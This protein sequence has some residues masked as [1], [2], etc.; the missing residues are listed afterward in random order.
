MI[1]KGNGGGFVYFGDF[2]FALFLLVWE[3]ENSLVEDVSTFWKFRII[4]SIKSSQ[5]LTYT[6]SSI[7]KKLFSQNTYKL[8]PLK[9]LL[10]YFQKCYA[11]TIPKSRYLLFPFSLHD[12]QVNSHWGMVRAKKITRYTLDEWIQ[13]EWMGENQRK[14]NGWLPL[15]VFFYIKGFVYSNYIYYF[16]CEICFPP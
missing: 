8:S 1:W 12:W 15:E 2:P 7:E 6:L 13:Q 10:D 16:T 11:M 4:S 5:N 14:L 3:R 9:N